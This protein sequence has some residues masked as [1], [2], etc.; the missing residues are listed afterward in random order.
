MQ[1]IPSKTH[2]SLT[3][4]NNLNVNHEM[5]LIHFTVVVY[6]RFLNMYWESENTGQEVFCY[7][8]STFLHANERLVSS[9]YHIYLFKLA[10]LL[11]HFAQLSLHHDFPNSFLSKKIWT[12][13]GLWF[14]QERKPRIQQ[15][16]TNFLN[17]KFI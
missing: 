8:R 1:V 12:L 6:F 7:M 15:S 9:V 16:Q 11:S 3:C 4:I 5:N 17:Q 10:V 2:A 13:C 14:P